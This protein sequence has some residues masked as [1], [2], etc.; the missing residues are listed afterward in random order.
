MHENST[1][2]F[3]TVL[4]HVSNFIGLYLITAI[5]AIGILINAGVLKILSDKSLK[6]KFYGCL[7]IKTFSDLSVCLFGVSYLNNTCYIC[8]ESATYWVMFYNIWIIK[9]PLRICLSV[10]TFLEVYLIMNRWISLIKPK[11]ISLYFRK[12]SVLLSFYTVCTVLG[13]P[14]IFSVELEKIE[15]SA[16]YKIV[17]SE[18]SSTIYFVFYSFFISACQILPVVLI[19]VFN[20]LSIYQFRK[21][22]SK[23]I[24]I[25]NNYQSAGSKLERRFTK[26]II[27]LSCLFF[28][29]KSLDVISHALSAFFHIKEDAKNELNSQANS[30]MNFSRQFS[31]LVNIGFSAFNSVLYIY[32]DSN[33]RNII[34][35]RMKSLWN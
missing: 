7:W 25:R 3:Y 4:N 23:T 19:V 20:I 34:K 16:E 8:K 17:S 1:V 22:I 5:A 12:L 11:S 33:L 28:V 30:L 6:H 9:F 29:C 21:T 32:T 24:A 26:T 18:Y 13:I 35:N 27:V 10:S 14:G 15:F 31:F 2:N